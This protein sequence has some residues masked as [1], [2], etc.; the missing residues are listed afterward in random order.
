MKWEIDY[1]KE[2]GIVYIKTSGQAT[3]EG[4]KK[5]SQ[6]GLTLGR[7]NNTCKYI[8][9]HRNMEHGLSVLQVDD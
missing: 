2:D 1:L 5:M 8:I 4:N 6:E 7:K 9:D 3:W